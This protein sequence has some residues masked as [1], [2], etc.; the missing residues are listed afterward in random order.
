MGN[1]VERE[2]KTEECDEEDGAMD[3]LGLKGGLK[4]ADDLEG[5]E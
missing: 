2:V 1:R 4:E 5:E 3:N